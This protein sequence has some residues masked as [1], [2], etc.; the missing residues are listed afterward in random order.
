M[1]SQSSQEIRSSW[2][3]QKA[4][5]I[6]VS[7]RVSTHWRQM[8]EC[9]RR[10]IHDQYLEYE[11]NFDPEDKGPRLEKGENLNTEALGTVRTP[12]GGTSAPAGQAQGGPS[13]A[14]MKEKIDVLRTMIKELDNLG[15]EKITPR[16]LFNEESCG[17]RSEN[18]QMIPSAKEAGGYFSDGSSRKSSPGSGYDTVSDSGSEDLSMPYRR[19]KPMPFTSRITRFRYH[20]RAK[21]LRNVRVYERNKDPKDHLSILQEEC[22][23]PVW[24]KM[25]RQT[26]SGLARNWFDS[27]DPKSVDGFEE[28]SNKFLEEFS[29]QKRYDEDP[30]E[31]H[32]IKR[33]PNERLQAFMDRFKVKRPSSGERRLQTPPK[34]LDLLGE[35]RVLVRLAGRKIRMGLEI[36][37]I[38]AMV[39]VKFHPPPPMVGT[40]EKQ[41][42]NKLCDYHQDWGHNTNDCYHLKK[43]IEET[44]AFGRLAHLVKDIRQGGQ[45]SKGSTKGKKGYQHGE[46]PRVPKDALREGRALDG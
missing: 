18:P 38:L 44:V 21:L 32:D 3:L 31:I 16:K 2:S 41:N 35:K 23:M 25:F 27:L 8:Y 20:R 33:K 34:S 5:S 9:H 14:F 46:I 7:I 43:H 1:S 28:L 22:P 24:C 12:L 15:Q 39:N 37:E 19:P 26:L 30:T 4:R 40:P 17:A 11:D 42:M 13:S 45:K 36:E 6:I 10:L 29:Q